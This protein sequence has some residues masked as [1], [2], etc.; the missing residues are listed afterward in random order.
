MKSFDGG[1]T[2]DRKRA[3]AHQIGG[4]KKMRRQSW[5]VGAGTNHGERHSEEV[6]ERKCERLHLRTKPPE[7]RQV[8]ICL[9]LPRTNTIGRGIELFLGTPSLLPTLQPREPSAGPL[10]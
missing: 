3:R 8:A 9:L 1:V 6:G 7:F 2:L 5:V 10:T 4:V